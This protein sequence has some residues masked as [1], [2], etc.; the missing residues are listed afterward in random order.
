MNFERMPKKTKW[1]GRIALCAVLVILV[2]T[3]L[4][5][6]D[7]LSDRITSVFAATDRDPIP[8]AV[9]ERQP[10][11][12]TVTA[13]GEITGLE[14]TTVATPNTNAGQLT[15]A[16]LVEEGTFVNAG[17]PI[18]RFDSTDAQLNLE[19]RQ[20]TLE[21]NQQNT[22]IRTQQ[23]ITD[24][25][26][27]SIDLRIAEENYNHAVT[28]M[29]EDETIFSRWDIIS[30]AADLRYNRE[31][32]D[33]LRH[34]I[35]TQQRDDRSKQQVLT[36]ARNQAQTEVNRLE[37][38]L[39]SLEVRAPVGGLVL[40]FR[41]RRSEPAVGDRSLPG[42]AVLEIVNLDALQARI[43]VLE[44][45][46]GFLERDLP[47]QIRLDAVPEKVYTGV[48]RTVS[49]VAQS[50]TRGSPLRYFTCEVTILDAGADMRRIRPGMNLRADVV[51]HEYESVFVVPSGA[52]TERPLQNDTV[53]HIQVGPDR[54]EPRMVEVGLG[55]H[56]EAV[57]LSGVQAGET[58]A[59][60][61]PAGPRQL[62][63]PDFNAAQTTTG[64]QPKAKMIM[65]MG[66]GGGM[67]GMGGG[68]GRGGR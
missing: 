2:G 40:Y 46:G 8:V 16:W 34:R 31:E 60:V 14:T 54:F 49:A 63:L 52:V 55:S 64:T 5:F 1:G 21:S 57:I 7:T 39:N 12:L 38:T 23:Q 67:G 18:I 29:P 58:I 66:P 53:V 28:V 61:D 47:V 26:I 42:Q 50:L 24:E 17:D 22:S 44:R 13:N 62:T 51:L 68:G 20:N 10:F 32:L 4:Y 11:S 48:I 30:T 45:D 65:Q 25:R 15:I 33:F 59:L 35:R 19:Q 36:I 41:D 27:R 3:A 6:R 43:H 37:Q 9:L 56:G